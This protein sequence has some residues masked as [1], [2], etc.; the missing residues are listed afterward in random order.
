MKIAFMHFWTLRLPRGVETL[1]ISLANEL[2]KHGHDVSILTAQ[3]DRQPLVTPLPSVAVKKFPTFRYY[4][5]ATIVPFYAANLIREKYDAVITFFADFGEGWALQLAAPF[6]HPKHVLYLTFPYKSAPHRY[7]A[8]Q[9]WQW[10]KKAEYI[11]ADAEYTAKEGTLFFNR[12]VT[13]LPSG[14]DPERFKP[15][16]NLRIQMRKELGFK[17]NDL[18]LLNVAALEQRK[19]VW[20]VIE[21]LPEIQKQCKN[22]RYLIL[23][24]GPQ[25]ETLQQRAAALN[26]TDNVIFAGTTTN[27]QAYYNAAD[28][29]VMLSDSEAG[30]I[31]CLEAMAS[32]LPVIV[33]NS[34]GFHE[35]VTPD[36]GRMINLEK[37]DELIEA[38][39]E[40]KNN[41]ELRHTLGMNGRQRIIQ[42]FSWGSLAGRLITILAENE[43]KHG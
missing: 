10:G 1:V 11:L 5:S 24:D 41:T 15:D 26:I 8:Y 20:R 16:A 34:G 2:S 42:E 22:V 25:K 30:S 40:L 7:K 28:I 6:T 19:G 12:P 17:D 32:G 18:I 43:N 9:H 31:A 38:V 33:S 36:C 37:Q 3:S 14:T 39:S 35:V 29:F 13:N 27:L 21:T 4:E 23:G